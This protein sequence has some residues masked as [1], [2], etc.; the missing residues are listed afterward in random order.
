LPYL[1]KEEALTATV[2]LS[3]ASIIVF[4]LPYE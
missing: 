3:V 4:V 1:S 2:T